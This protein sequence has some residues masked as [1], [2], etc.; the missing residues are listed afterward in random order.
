MPE[1]VSIVGF[2]DL[3]EAEFFA[4]P[5]T[6]IR[7]DFGELGRRAMVLVERV[8]GR[9]GERLGRP[10]ADHA[11][12]PGAPRRRPRRRTRLATGASVGSFLAQA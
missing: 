6:T 11:G 10:G 9:R 4:P 8:L 7:Q 5:L 2:D 12:R 1:D 3:P